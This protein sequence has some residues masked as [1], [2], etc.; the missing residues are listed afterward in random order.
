MTKQFIKQ[1]KFFYDTYNFDYN[2]IQ[3]WEPKPNK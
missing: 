3:I 2:T 1:I